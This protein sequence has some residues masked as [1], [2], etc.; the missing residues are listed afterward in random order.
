MTTDE[1][2]NVVQLTYKEIFKINPLSTQFS[3][4]EN[5]RVLMN[6]AYRRLFL[7]IR[8]TSMKGPYEIVTCSIIRKEEVIDFICE[9]FP[10]EKADEIFDL[11][12]IQGFY[13]VNNG[14][15][16]FMHTGLHWL[17]AE[18]VCGTY[19]YDREDIPEDVL[20]NMGIHTKDTFYSFMAI[21]H[22]MLNESDCFQVRKEYRK[23][24]KN[25]SKS[26]KLQGPFSKP[27]KVRLLTLKADAD[28]TLE[29][30]TREYKDYVRH[31]PAWGVRGHYRHMKSGKIV[32][33]K[34]HVKGQRK[35][36]YVGRI[37]ELIQEE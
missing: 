37:Y 3:C 10:E 8:P 13:A 36:L 19:G 31:C 30:M 29:R 24:L 23:E 21:Q 11:V 20:E 32:Y 4:E 18:G 6:P 2:P 17:N 27:G 26:R 33:V 14:V 15:R 5:K 28:S 9:R 16:T 7:V 35:D 12:L 1:K 22:I 25:G 34:P